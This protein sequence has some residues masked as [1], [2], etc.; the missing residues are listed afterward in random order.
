MILED[1]KLNL[2]DSKKTDFNV[3]P[4]DDYLIKHTLWPE[5]N[6][7]YAHP[8]EMEYLCR[9]PDSKLMASS[10][11]GLT[12]DDSQVI[13]WDTSDWKVFKILS[14]HSYTVYCM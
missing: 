13:I 12:K 8:H 3:P 2:K 7:L 14:H 4:H 1:E 11:T 10:C 6:K 5:M 9:S